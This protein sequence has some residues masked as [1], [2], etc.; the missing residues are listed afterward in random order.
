[1]LEG[2]FLVTDSSPGGQ[3]VFSY[4]ELKDGTFRG[5][6]AAS[7]ADI[8]T[9]KGPLCDTKFHLRVGTINFLGHPTMLNVD[10]PNTGLIYSRKVQKAIMQSSGPG[11]TTTMFHLVFAI[12]DC[13][14]DELDLIYEHC[15]VRLTQ[16]FKF[17]QLRRAY[18][19]KESEIIMD[20]KE[21]EKQSD[22]P[23]NLM[24]AIINGSSLART[25]VCIY[26]S[27]KGEI[28]PHIVINGSVRLS[29]QPNLETIRSIDLP[30]ILGSNTQGILA[31]RPYK[32]LLLLHDPVD[33]LDRLPV[34]SSPSLIQLIQN[35]NPALSFEQLQTKLNMPLSQ[36]YKI[37]SHLHYWGQGRIIQAVSTKNFYVVSAKADFT[38]IARLQSEFTVKFAP[39]ELTK[40]LS[41]ISQP[42]PLHTVIPEKDMRV[43]YL[44][45]ISFLLRH[46]IIL[47]LHMALVL[48][49]PKAVTE[50]LS[51]KRDAKDLVISDPT[52]P[53]PLAKL[54]IEYLCST[55]HNPVILELFQRILPHINGQTPLDEIMFQENLSRQVVT[56]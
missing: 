48:I 13:E 6:G 50:K 18:I 27:M 10:R 51:N 9:P 36:I 34:G 37:S 26:R 21:K 53:S 22:E 35:V 12:T 56:N 43:V 44:E 41:D 33:V 46:E 40:V 23:S 19:R 32:A 45:A 3:L 55:I 29:I 11:L 30:I 28:P 52:S 49:I 5:F 20:I 2:V 47:Q 17:E 31:L 38:A 15:L 42:K 8:L 39:L 24:Q 14:N 16:G 1:M 25:L 54:S 4:P 7:L